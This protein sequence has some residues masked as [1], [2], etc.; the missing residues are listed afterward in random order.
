MS[1]LSIIIPCLNCLTEATKPCVESIQCSEDYDLIIID[2]GCTDGTEE[3]F[4]K[5]AIE[6]NIPLE[7]LDGREINLTDEERRKS[8]QPSN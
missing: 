5:L 8:E 4:G 7:I 1:D 6:K 3:Y 2:N